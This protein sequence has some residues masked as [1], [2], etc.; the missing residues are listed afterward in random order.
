MSQ[1]NHTRY[2]LTQPYSTHKYLTPHKTGDI[3][4]IQMISLIILGKDYN[5]ILEPDKHVHWEFTSSL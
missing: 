4:I 2:K 5:F 1:Y 3:Y